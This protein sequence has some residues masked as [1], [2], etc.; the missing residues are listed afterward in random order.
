[1]TY[2]GLLNDLISKNIIPKEGE[3]Y[4]YYD[5]PLEEVFDFFWNY[6][7]AFLE[8]KDLGFDLQ[9]PKLYFNTNTLTNGLAYVDNNISGIE[10]FKGTIFSLHGFFESKAKHFESE[11]ML[12]YVKVAKRLKISPS[13]FM[14]QFV[15]LLFLY[16]ETGHL[17]QRNGTTDA[18][19][20]FMIEKCVGTEEESH[21]KEFDADWFAANQ[22]AMQITDLTRNIF[23]KI[24]EEEEINF[25]HSSAELALA[26]VYVFMIITS[27][28]IP[29]LYYQK[30]CHPHP[31]V[32]LIYLIF[33][34]IDTIKLQINLTL[35][36]D[37]ILKNA[38]IIS[39]ELMHDQDP[40]PVQIYS[41]NIYMNLDEIDKYV[42]KLQRD[43]NN[44]PRASRNNLT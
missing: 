8:R 29:E 25:L 22:L 19:L 24:E 17:I 30:R 38:I 14:F 18:S 9:N 15:G 10:I 11:I 34:F 37:R 7:Q 23:G 12:P 26:S 27:K 2:K 42:N 31:S 20:E 43:C 3:F 36:Q 1:M 33:Y 16:H 13:F 40:N 32:R 28:E 41:N 4:D 44:Y 6:G 21:V 5:F 39:L 35:D